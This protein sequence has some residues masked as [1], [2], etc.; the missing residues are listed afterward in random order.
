MTYIQHS[1]E[2]KN[3]NKL[4]NKSKIFEKFNSKQI[5]EYNNIINKNKTSINKIQNGLIKNVEGKA[6]IKDK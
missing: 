5:T 1:Q 4:S 6:N 2:K 3:I